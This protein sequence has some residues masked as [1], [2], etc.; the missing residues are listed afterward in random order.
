MWKYEY[1]DKN[2]NKDQIKNYIIDEL[3]V[4]VDVKDNKFKK[5][6]KNY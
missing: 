6:L 1:N 4:N 3:V 2:K 5:N